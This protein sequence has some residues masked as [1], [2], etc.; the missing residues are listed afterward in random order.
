MSLNLQ[1]GSL[2]GRVHQLE[3]DLKRVGDTHDNM[4]QYMMKRFA[5]LGVAFG[6]DLISMNARIKTIEEKLGI[7]LPADLPP[8]PVEETPATDN[9]EPELP[10]MPEPESKVKYHKEF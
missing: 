7:E 1:A 8:E 2:A 6:A 3:K 9:K 10:G 5:D 4:A